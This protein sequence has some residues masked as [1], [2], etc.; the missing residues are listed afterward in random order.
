MNR[1][2]TIPFSHY[3]E[4][5]RWAL[6]RAH[7]AYVEEP[8]LP[9]ISSVAARRAGGTRTVPVLVTAERTIADSTE[10]L[11]W[12]DGR[13]GVSPLFPDGAV[14]DEVRA[15]EHDFD[16]RLG[17]HARRLAYA[18]VL[19]SRAASRSLFTAV[20]AWEARTVKATFPLVRGLMMKK[21]KITPAAIAR[22]RTIVDDTFAA[23]AARLADGRRFLA[24]DRFTA[25]DLTFATLAAPVIAPEQYGGP[26]PPRATWPSDYATYIDAMRRTPA[27]AFALRI[28][29]EERVN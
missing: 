2:I 25:A 15:L 26:L 12:C 22:S 5:A 13:N 11:R 6:D 4:K 20:P 14:G 7:V 24:G 28:Y 19:P 27:G 10:I 23:V 9:I 3:C 21:L 1:L 29:G 18:A 8:H 17:P 16:E